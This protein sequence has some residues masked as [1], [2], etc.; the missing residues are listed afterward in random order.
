[1]FLGL[2][3]SP[4]PRAEK[5]QR[6]EG[7]LLESSAGKWRAEAILSLSQPWAGP[8]LTGAHRAQVLHDLSLGAGPGE[9]LAAVQAPLLPLFCDRMGRGRGE[10]APVSQL[11]G[12]LKLC[13]VCSRSQPSSAL[14][15]LQTQGVSPR[16]YQ[17]WVT[18]HGYV[19]EGALVL[20]F[21]ILATFSSLSSSGTSVETLH[22]W[23][24]HVLVWVL[25]GNLY[26]LL[27]LF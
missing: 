26:D 2:I 3:G 1:M 14:E 15:N 8:P 23:G 13:W 27:I 12:K 9:W 24:R 21:L 18:R 25:F 20:T 6:P 4:C 17:S 5:P 10:P 7:D 11:L 16:L 19:K 22:V